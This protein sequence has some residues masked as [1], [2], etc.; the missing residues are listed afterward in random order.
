MDTRLI[1]RGDDFGISH[2]CNLAIEDCFHN[3]ILTCAA[4]IAPAPWAEEAAAMARAHPEWCVGAHLTTLGEWRGYRWRPVLPYDKVNTIVDEYGFLHQTPDAFFAGA[5]DFDQ[6]EREFMAQADLITNRWGVNLG[7]ADYHYINGNSHNAPEYGRVLQR[8]AKA[9]GLK[10][11]GYEGES[12]FCSIYNTEPAKKAETFLNALDALKPG[13]YL[14]VHHLLR[15]NA[16]SRGLL[17]ANTEDE[18]TEGSAA[19]R[20]AEAAVLMNPAVKERI[21]ACGIKLISYRDI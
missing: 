5:V 21:K 2:S 16:E 20:A 4:I 19:H 3:G 10:L 13:L 1:I 12:R 11:S 17:Y 15:D 6:L 7:Y 8:V 9:Y 14:S 18:K